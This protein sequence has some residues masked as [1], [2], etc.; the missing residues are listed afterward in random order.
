[1]I[2]LSLLHGKDIL[3]IE[4]VIPMPIEKLDDFPDHPFQVRQDEEMEDL[5]E[6]VK[7]VG[8]IE[9]IIARP[10]DNG[11]YEII[12]G[13]RRK[14]AGK[15]AN[16]KEVP[17]IIRNY[18]D[19]EAIIIMV[20]SNHQ[21]ENILPSEKAYAYK[22]RL[23]AEKRQGA[24]TDLTSSQVAT[25]FKNPS[26]QHS[27]ADTRAALIVAGTDYAVPAYIVGSGR[28]QV[29]IDGVLCAGGSDTD[30]CVYSEVGAKGDA[31]TAIQFHQAI[32]TDYEIIVRVQ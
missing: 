1:M 15:L 28:L 10:K 32:A 5:V 7:K 31:S 3:N 20:D 13:H 4:K 25:K 11:H 21:R 2:Y 29:F 19:D 27:P 6:R 17:T 23:E 22:M 14:L 8:V 26:V 9:P 16:L 18:N 24:R 12:S 30:A